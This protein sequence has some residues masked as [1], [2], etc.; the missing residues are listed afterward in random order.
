MIHAEWVSGGLTPSTDI[1]DD[2]ITT[3]VADIRPLIRSRP[4]GVNIRFAGSA[5][6]GSGSGSGSGW[7]GSG[8]GGSGSAGSGSGLGSDGPG[9]QGPGSAGLG[10]AATRARGPDSS[11]R[12]HRYRSALEATHRLAGVCLTV[13]IAASTLA[14]AGRS[15]RRTV[16]TWTDHARSWPGPWLD[17]RHVANRPGESGRRDPAPERAL[18]WVIP[19]RVILTPAAA[20]DGAVTRVLG[21]RVVW[22]HNGSRHP[23]LTDR[24]GPPPNG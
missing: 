12:C 8:S 11:P 7:D 1:V 16:G 21:R 13:H 6:S 23:E 20:P 9:S 19:M 3:G 2:L 24:R 22:Q 4:T 5:G 10:S 14:G 18:G 17:P 15:S